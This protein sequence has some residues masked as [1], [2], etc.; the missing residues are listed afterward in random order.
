[1]RVDANAIAKA[2]DEM[3]PE[4][5]AEWRECYYLGIMVCPFGGRHR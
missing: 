5:F 2:I 3:T 1:M 4:G